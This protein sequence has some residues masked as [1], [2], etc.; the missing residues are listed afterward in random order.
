MP[1]TDRSKVVSAQIQTQG[2]RSY[3]GMLTDST[4]YQTY[5][6]RFAQ[7]SSLNLKLTGLKA[8]A[9]LAL[10]DNN[11]R[12]LARSSHKG[13][14]N[15]AIAFP[16]NAT[17]YQV[18]VLRQQG[19]TKYQLKLSV[20]P[21]QDTVVGQKAPPTT[22]TS[23]ALINRVLK[24]TN[25]FRKQMGLRSLRLN[26][27]LT[28]AAQAHSEDMALKDFFAHEG[29]NGSQLSDRLNKVGYKA[30]TAAE[31]I[32]GGYSTPEAAIQSWI[33]SPGH[34]ANLLN[35]S[36]KEIGIGFYF[37]SNDSG[38]TAYRYYWTQDFGSPA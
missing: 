28:K 2:Q 34:R 17:T 5:K 32:A 25:D 1:Q 14:S 16:V 35:S 6:F 36:A 37:L 3:K 7:H 23:P 11:G 24:L 27:K 19:K 9:D 31:N 29:S 13:R 4:P 22:A 15:E 12:V 18:R 10:M 26:P 38:K 21:I 20:A 33:N 30:K 8:D